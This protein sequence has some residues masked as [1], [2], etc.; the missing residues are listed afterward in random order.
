[1]SDNG[2]RRWATGGPGSKKGPS[3]ARRVE[4]ALGLRMAR[5]GLQYTC[6]EERAALVDAICRAGAERRIYLAGPAAD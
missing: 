1:M 5:I 4:S 2:N 6:E 3:P